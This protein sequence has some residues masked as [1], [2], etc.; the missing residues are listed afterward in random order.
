MDSWHVSPAPYARLSVLNN[1]F[2]YLNDRLF[3][4][5]P[6]EHVKHISR[7]KEREREFPATAVETTFLDDTLK[8]C[9]SKRIESTDKP[10]EERYASRDEECNKT[11]LRDN[12]DFQRNDRVS[13]VTSR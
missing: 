7:E 6:R 8:S 4:A 10:N 5:V 11:A 2:L 1:F 12:C 9:G 13:C 3:R